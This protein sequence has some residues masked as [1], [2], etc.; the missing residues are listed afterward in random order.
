MAGRAGDRVNSALGK[1]G[2]S[3]IKKVGEGSFGAAILVQDSND[4]ERDSKAIVKMIDISRASKQE[5]DDALKESRVLSQLRHPYIVRYRENFLEDGWLCIVMDYCEGG[6]LSAKIKRAKDQRKTFP[7]EQVLRWFTQSILALKYIHDLHILHRDLKSGNFFLSKSGNVKMGDFGIAKVLECT[8]ACA[9]TQIGTPYYLSPEI[10]QGKPYAWGSDIWSMG[11]IL[12]EMAARKVP[13]DAPDLKTLIKRITSG[14]PPELPS[15]YSAG[16]K[17]LCRELLSR[18]PDDRPPAAEI[19]KRPVVQEVVR[20]M[21]E[22]VKGEE[23][24]GESSAAP[25]ADRPA[26][27]SGKA[28]ARP[29]RSATTDYRDAAGTY[30]KNDH[31]EYYSAT[32]KEWLP[33][34]IT[35]VDADGR[36]QLNVKPNVWLG[37][38][39][40]S[41]KVRPKGAGAATDGAA[42]EAGPRSMSARPPRGGEAPVGSPVRRA[43]ERRPDSC[44]RQPSDGP[45]MRRQSS[46]DGI[47][48]QAR[49]SDRG[50]PSARQPSPR[51]DLGG[52]AAYRGS[53]PQRG[54]VAMA[55]AGSPAGA[56]GST[57]SRRR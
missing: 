41:E 2:Y 10:C 21:L 50:T 16:L 32:H 30:K 28:A 24:K 31:V 26:A 33:A 22:E 6:D 36:I 39:V 13:F 48:V 11:C 55:A 56:R 23:E 4:R 27:A 45:A 34:V 25:A 44:R 35:N 52:G 7:E 47:G 54:A 15:E 37:M 29:A 18:N 40:Q 42:E 12:Y 1:H 8:A 20:R 53:T 14:S 57:P 49:G 43:E 38:E 51:R 17:A 5:R 9:Q 46:R 3:Q 19:L